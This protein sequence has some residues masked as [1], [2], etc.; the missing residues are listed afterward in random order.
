MAKKYPKLSQI[1]K[2][3]LFE[4]NMRPV[5]LARE[6]N[7]PSPT[8]HRIV[9]GK[10]TRPYKESL[11]AISKYLGVSINQ[12]T[13][14]EPLLPETLEALNSSPISKQVKVIP[15]LLWDK[16]GL[17][18]NKKDNSEL[19]VIN[20][21]DQ[22]FATIMPDYSMEPLFQ[23]GSTLIFDPEREV[24][25]RNYVLVKLY[26]PDIYVFRQLLIDVNQ[27]FIKSLNADISA[28]SIRLLHPQDKIIARLVEVRS[29]L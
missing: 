27:K 8:V 12:L 10:S 14:E 6:L 22:A 2:K 4:K 29:Q 24:T 1:L 25:D 15:L 9:T 26:N 3:L 21:S 28:A 18:H 19:V 17:S 23:K 20:V 5:D 11:E 16:L 7:M 13:G